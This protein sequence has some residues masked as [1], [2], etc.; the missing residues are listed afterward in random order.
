MPAASTTSNE[1]TTG[2]GGSASAALAE[3][4]KAGKPISAMKRRKTGP[5]KPILQN[6]FMAVKP[7][8]VV[9]RLYLNVPN[10]CFATCSMRVAEPSSNIYSAPIQR[11]ADNPKTTMDTSTQMIKIANSQ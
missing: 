11:G 2:D 5:R 4:D 7:R 3:S 10:G 6:H 1:M 8:G 9:K